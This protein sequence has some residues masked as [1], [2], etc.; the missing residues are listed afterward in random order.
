MPPIPE[1]VSSNKH[2]GATLAPNSQTAASIM[3]E[4]LVSAFEPTSSW[5]YRFARYQALPEI[6]GMP[7]AKAG[8]PFL[9][10]E[11]TAEVLDKHLTKEQQNMT[12]A[13]RKA[14]GVVKVSSSVKFFVPFMAEQ[15][16]ALINLG[17]GMFRLPTPDD[18]NSDEVEAEALDAADAD[19][20]EEADDLSGWI[21]AFTFPLIQA[22]NG[23]FPIKIGKT[24]NDVA[25]R[26][27]GQCKSS[28]VFEQPKILAS[29]KVTR[30]SYTESAIHCILKARGR[31]R[32]EA[33]G[34]EWF[35]TTQA[36]IEEIVR[37][38]QS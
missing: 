13:R 31:W 28:A 25:S 37:F 7:A 24:A 3:T 16:Q 23:P 10:R 34:V 33:P 4:D 1:H 30:M 22:A 35:D 18:E 36:E 17:K 29:W 27:A 14:E 2:D 9:L 12:Y 38:I 11:C 21:Y 6:L 15:S 26:V 32:E 20:V 8:Q 5:C 19:E